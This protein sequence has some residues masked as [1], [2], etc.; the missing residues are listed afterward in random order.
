MWEPRCLTTVWASTA[1]YRDSFT[2]Y[3]RACILLSMWEAQGQ[4]IAVGFLIREEERNKRS[5]IRTAI[6][7]LK[8]TQFFFMFIR[9]EPENRRAVRFFVSRSLHCHCREGTYWHWFQIRLSLF[10]LL[11]FTTKLSVNILAHLW[12]RSLLQFSSCDH[13]TSHKPLLITLPK[14]SCSI[15]FKAVKASADMFL[16][17]NICF[18]TMTICLTVV[19]SK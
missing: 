16:S 6:L 14:L 10:S 15:Y 18:V 13:R 19:G 4:R 8:E 12:A 3:I 1:C 5:A 17:A 11:T 2:F 9:S 7:Y